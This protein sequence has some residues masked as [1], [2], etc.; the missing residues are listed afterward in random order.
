MFKNKSFL[1]GFSLLIL[2]QFASSQNNTNSPYTRFG[3]GELIDANSGEQRAMGGVS[4]GA[5]SNKYI[6]SLN[7]ASYSAVDSMTFMFDLGSSALISRFSQP[8]GSKTTFNANL[9][10]ISLQFP[11][12]KWLG[13]SAGVLPYSFSG[14]DFN[15]KDTVTTPTS[16]N[17]S[18]TIGYTS[19]FSGQG[20]FSQVY[21][22]VSANFFNHI[23]VGINA[24]YMFGSLNNYRILSFSNSTN[25]TNE[26]Q[27]KSIT[28]T[29]QKNSIT[30]NNLRFRYGAQFYNTFADK[31]DLTLGLIYEQ[32]TKFNGNFS[33]VKFDS[34]TDTMS[35]AG[36]S[37]FELPQTLGAGVFYTFDKKISVGLDYSLQQ[38]AHARYF[39]QTDSLNNRSKISV[40][41]EYIPNPRARKFADK[42]H[43]RAGFNVSDSYYNVNGNI[44]P[45][46][47][48]ISF[49]LGLPLYNKATNTVSMLNTTF[50]Y[51]KIGSSSLLREDYFKFS[52]NVVFN[53]HWFFKSKL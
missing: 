50:E 8:T 38:W 1:L 28:S 22:G 42:I 6:N 49:G 53:E 23:S 11:I 33:Q 9:E 34:Q 37:D 7:P 40:G 27:L 52:L 20:G 46:N 26:T 36:S 25:A 12:Y 19:S 44:P 21:G 14:Y 39:G 18:D 16:T 30:A 4:F 15:Q 45:K 10:Y 2:S 41:L 35:V 24:Y 32:K 47:F 3:Y 43:Y 29:T 13:F 48:G 51:G 31:H 5:R 17:V